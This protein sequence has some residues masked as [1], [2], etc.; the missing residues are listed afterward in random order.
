MKRFLLY[1]A[2]FFA[3]GTFITV[4]AL[5]IVDNFI[6]ELSQT[7]AIE[8]TASSKDKQT[9]QSGKQIVLPDGVDN[10]E[11]SFDNKYY[12]YLKDDKININS[13]ENG[14]SVKVIEEDKPICYSKL[15]YDKNLIL[16]FTKTNNATS[17][18]TQLQLKTYEISSEKV[19]EYNV[20]NVANFS[21][22]KDMNMSPIINILYINVETKNNSRINN[23]IYRIDLFNSMSQVKSGV[24]ID[25]MIMAQNKDR[26][27]YED[28]DDNV[29]YSN[30]MIKL[31]KKDVELIGIDYEDRIY[32]LDKTERNKVYVINN[33]N[34]V[35]D[36]IELS[37]SDLVKTYT[38]NY[39]V[40]LI[41]P[42]YVLNVAGEDPYKRI[43][44]FSKYV[45]FES[46][47]GDV[48]YLK[49]SNNVL[50]QS[51]LLEN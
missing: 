14:E 1:I 22:I 20:F 50:I 30:S 43:G 45:T 24:I 2:I 5:T 31:F 48:M 39:G 21:K 46:I 25:K 9:L 19:S 16:Y 7:S 36:T 41:Y 6:Y 26:I 28:E 40:Y 13:L 34:V 32:F 11:Y 3:I 37:D 4:V 35:I 47:K 12:V 15:M 51:D 33:N 42:T 44:K 23:V 49:T 27:Y 10:V 18:S 38:N 8:T 17:Y 29:Y